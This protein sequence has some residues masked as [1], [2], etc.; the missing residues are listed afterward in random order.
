MNEPSAGNYYPVN[1]ATY[2]KDDEAQLSILVDRSQGA[3]SLRNGELELMVHRRTLFDD[4]RGKYQEAF[5]S[6]LEVPSLNSPNHW[7]CRCGRTHQRD[8]NRYHPRNIAEGRRWY[9]CKG[10]TLPSLVRSHGSNVRSA[11]TYGRGI[12]AR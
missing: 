11:L 7:A 8:D 6:V 2:I 9:Y 5:P 3:A 4:A 12:P 10:D 1:A